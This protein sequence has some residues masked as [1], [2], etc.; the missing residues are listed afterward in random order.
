MT[1]YQCIAQAFGLVGLVIIVYSFQCKENKNFFILQGAGSFMFFLNFIMISAYG[2]ALFNLVNFVRGCLFSKNDKKPW[3]LVLVEIL[4]SL[5]FAFS[6]VLAKGDNFQILLSAIPCIALLIIS[7]LMWKGDA[8]VIRFFQ[9]FCMSPAW[10][11]HNIFNFTLGGLICE[12]F[13]MISVV[14]Y[15]I[16]CKKTKV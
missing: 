5:C 10:I 3:K 14:V 15:F 7:V 1:V 11:V 13:N 12:T 6:V 9:L 4:Y 8:R 16:R 2:G